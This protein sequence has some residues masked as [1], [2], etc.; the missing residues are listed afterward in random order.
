MDYDLEFIEKIVTDYWKN[1]MS[2]TPKPLSKYIYDELRRIKS[3]RNSIDGY[4]DNI[5]KHQEESAKKIADEQ[6]CIKDLRKK[7]KHE[8]TKYHPDASGNN[9]SWTEC[10][11]CGTTL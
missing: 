4:W 5:R 2:V 10:L 6:I 7:C 1:N 11:I 8:V 3:I 9:D